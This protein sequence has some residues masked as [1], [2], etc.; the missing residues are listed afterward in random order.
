MTT[1][2]LS[3][4][5]QLYLQTAKENSESLANNYVKISRGSLDKDHL[6]NMYINAHSLKSKS[7]V[8]GYLKI[9][10]LSGIIEKTIKNILANDAQIPHG[11]M[12]VIKDAI[13][14]IQASLR[15]IEAE[16]KEKGTENITKKLE[17]M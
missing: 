6:N 5:K 11:L 10:A 4:Y 14:N 16:N 9:G 7:Q 17:D 8:M 1:V 13:D 15:N 3:S 2:N 12:V